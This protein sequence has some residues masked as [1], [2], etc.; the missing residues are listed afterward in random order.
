MTDRERSLFDPA[1][2]SRMSCQH[3]VNRDMDIVVPGFSIRDDEK[4]LRDFRIASGGKG[5][6]IAIDLGTTLIALYLVDLESGEIISQHAFVNPQMPFGGDV[7]SRLEA[8]KKD[9]NR[10][11]MTDL[12]R[13]RVAEVITYAICK[14]R[15]NRDDVGRLFVAGNTAITHFWLG[16]GGEGLEKAPF[17]SVFEGKGIIPFDPAIVGLTKRCGSEVCPILSGF[18]G[19]DTT[20]AIIAADLDMSTGSSRQ[21]LLIDLGANGEIVLSANGGLFA[22]STAAGPAFEGVGMLAGMPALPGAIEGFTERHE[23]VVIGGGKPVGFC[24]VV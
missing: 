21:R 15:I 18:I 23:P 2:G 10:R 8:A 14:N 12:I 20:S 6:G 3:K 19:G 7:M 4:K 22:T 9:R 16:R 17:R 11:M 5:F 13:R 1:G 24:A